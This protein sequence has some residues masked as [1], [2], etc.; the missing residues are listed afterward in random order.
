M[1]YLPPDAGIWAVLVI[2]LVKLFSS[3]LVAFLPE[4]LRDYFRER[5]KLKT[6]QQE[7]EQAIQIAERN[8]I[9]LKELNELSKDSFTSE[10]ATALTSEL[11]VQLN[12]ANDFIMR[13]VSDKLD[14]V[15]EKLD[16]VLRELR[17]KNGNGN[18]TKRLD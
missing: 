13:I 10:Q 18:G 2:I 12:T 15:I 6:D 9:R 17:A 1:H 11:Q 4:A 8:L 3:Q 7:H 5:F 16:F 14:I